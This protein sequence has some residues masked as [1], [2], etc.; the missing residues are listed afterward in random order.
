MK[1]EQYNGVF[2]FF[3]VAGQ[4]D[5][6]IHAI[7]DTPR[8]VFGK[9]DL[10]MLVFSNNNIKSLLDIQNWLS[11]IRNYYEKSNEP[12]P[13]FIV[14]NN[15]MDLDG[16]IDSELIQKIKEQ[17]FVQNYFEI[18]CLTGSGVNDLKYWLEDFFDPKKEG[19]YL[20]G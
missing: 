7:R 8:A 3:D 5:L 14:V 18:S 10:V 13:S 11:L 9:A 1:P 16:T 20:N 4:L 17:D 2:Q 15:K 6:P 12:F 19:N